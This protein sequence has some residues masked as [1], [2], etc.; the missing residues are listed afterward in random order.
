MLETGGVP[1]MR[2]VP[3]LRDME[4]NDSVR[5]GVNASAGVGIGGVFIICVGVSGETFWICFCMSSSSPHIL[6]R[7]DGRELG[8][9][10]GSRPIHSNVKFNQVTIERSELCGKRI[11]SV[12]P[13]FY[14]L[15]V[16][17][18]GLIFDVWIRPPLLVIN[19]SI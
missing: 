17:L 3:G 19:H 9:G 14:G 16:G 15:F 18:P 8:V 11:S 13:F 10:L 5:P 1:K 6:C 12:G 7:R 4:E 2:G